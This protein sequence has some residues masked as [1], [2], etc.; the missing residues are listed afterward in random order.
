MR[1]TLPISISDHW[2]NSIVTP[3]LYIRFG[4]SEASEVVLL[5]NNSPNPKTRKS[6]GVKVENLYNGEVE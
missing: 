5:K 4:V 1:L 3:L 2:F 6:N